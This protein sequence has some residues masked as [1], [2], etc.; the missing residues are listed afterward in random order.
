MYFI[1]LACRLNKAGKRPLDAL[2][3]E[4]VDLHQT[5]KPH[6]IKV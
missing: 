4:M 2:I 1:E 6:G 5:K 3:Q